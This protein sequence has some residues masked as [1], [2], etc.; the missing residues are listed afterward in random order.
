M[1][2]AKKHTGIVVEMSYK[3]YFNDE[4]GEIDFKNPNT[5]FTI[6]NGGDIEVEYDD[7]DGNR[8]TASMERIYEGTHEMEG[9]F[10]TYT[11][12]QFEEELDNEKC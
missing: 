3:V 7:T 11:N 8:Q 12:E 6:L 9:H 5:Q 10:E 2:Q 4:E 1:E